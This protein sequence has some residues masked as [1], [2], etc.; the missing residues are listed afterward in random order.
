MRIDSA[1]GSLEGLSAGD[2]V[3]Q[4]FPVARRF[5]PHRDYGFDTA[6][7]PRRI[8]DPDAPLAARWRITDG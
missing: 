3:G 7:V 1:L 2:G 5:R 6:G 4:R 8:G